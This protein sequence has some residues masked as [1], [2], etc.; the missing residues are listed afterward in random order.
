[1]PHST[2]RVPRDSWFSPRIEVRN[3]PLDGRGTFAKERIQADEIVEIWGEHAHGRLAV[4][5]TADQGAALAARGDGKAVMQRDTDLFSIEEKGA[6]EGYFLNHS[7]DSNL[8]L[9][10]AFTLA[11]RRDIKPGEELT[12][13]YA[14]FESDESFVAS[15]RCACNSAICR[16]VLTGKDWQ[17]AHVQ[18]RYAGHF[19]APR[20]EKNCQ[21][22]QSN[23][24]SR[25]Q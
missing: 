7:C 4:I 22:R 3:S 9:E 11:A 18:T 8:W 14:V 19:S 10:G 15:W 21:V 20:R 17:R 24:R 13:D 2:V 25:N 23:R 1:M 6:D 5:Y 12:I 16:D